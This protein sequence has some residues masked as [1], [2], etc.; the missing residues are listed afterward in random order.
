[1]ASMAEHH[2]KESSKTGRF[3][4]GN[5]GRPKGARGKRSRET[6]KEI[7]ALGYEKP[8]I[9]LLKI[10]HDKNTPPSVAVTALSAA[11]PY[12]EAKFAPTAAPRLNSTPISLTPPTTAAEVRE[13]VSMLVSRAA[14]G[15]LALDVALDLVSMLKTYL[16]A[17]VGGDLE[18]KLALIESMGSQPT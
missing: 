9:S 3:R 16:I 8:S 6:L 2:R 10:A 15:E 18:A 17:L 7:A 4:T 5:A 14:A 1:M 11:A 12:V 13:Q